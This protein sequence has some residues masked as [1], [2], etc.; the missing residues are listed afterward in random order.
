MSD[1][2]MQDILLYTQHIEDIASYMEQILDHAEQLL[3]RRDIYWLTSI[4]GSEVV[5]RRM[6]EDVT[7]YV[8]DENTRIGIRSVSSELIRDMEIFI[9][10]IKNIGRQYAR[11]I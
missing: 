11:V 2:D 1:E 7:R 5:M 9:N 8:D 4:A 10:G 6:S 3:Q